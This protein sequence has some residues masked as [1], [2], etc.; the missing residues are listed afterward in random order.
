MAMDANTYRLPGGNRAAT[1]ALIVGAIG[2]V[3]S[4][5]AYFADGPRFFHSYLTAYVFWVSIGLGSLFFTMLHYL[6]GAQWSITL[7]RLVECIMISLPVMAVLFIP[8]ALGLHD[9]YHWSHAD[10]VAGDHL[11]QGK[12][13]YLNVPFFIIRTVLY[14]AIWFILAFFLYRASIAEDSGYDEARRARLRRLSAG[15]MILFAFTTTFAAFDWLMSL[16]AH[17]Y[18]TIFGA[19]Y[20][21]G[22][23]IG[24]L[25]FVTLVAIYLRKQGLLGDVITVEHYNDL[26]KLTFAFMI[27]WAYMA[28]SQYFLIWYGNI[29][30]ETIW[31]AHRWEGSW[32][33]VSLALVFGH[34]VIPFILLMPKMVKR[35]LGFMAAISV[36]LLLAHWLDMFWLVLPSHSHHGAAFSWIDIATMLG[37]GGI[38]VGLFWHR[39]GAHALIPVGDPKLEASLHS[40]SH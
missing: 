12:S 17:W 35:K 10:A 38:F 7:R 4:V 28:F 6:V 8:I 20:F 39:L 25:C 15:G 36:W 23:V 13:P 24:A 19:Y 40:L 31:F 9:L 1:V 18:S 5:I 3:A 29:P 32:K 37:I 21:A 2:V 22:C 11:L 27:F 26:G 14:F 33:A 16:D 30:E 34:F